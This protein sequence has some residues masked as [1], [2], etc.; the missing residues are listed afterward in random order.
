MNKGKWL[1][2]RYN[3]DEEAKGGV[4]EGH[5]LHMIRVFTKEL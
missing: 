3:S 4:T 5:E 2:S 1:I